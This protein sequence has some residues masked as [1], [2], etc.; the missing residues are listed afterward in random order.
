MSIVVNAVARIGSI[1]ATR[2]EIGIV[3]GSVPNAGTPGRTRMMTCVNTWM[4]TAMIRK[5]FLTVALVALVAGAGRPASRVEQAARLSEATMAD[6]IWIST[7]GNLNAAGSYSPSGVPIA[8]GNIVFDGSSNVDVSTGL[9]GLTG[10]DLRR[11]WTQPDYEGDIGASGN[12]LTTAA[13]R[14]IVQGSGSV[15]YAQET[16]SGGTPVIVVDSPNQQDAFSLVSTA[17]AYDLY[18]QN[19]GVEILPGAGVLGYLGVASRQSHLLPNVTIGTGFSCSYYV[20][21]SGYVTSKSKLGDTSCVIDGGIFV[22]DAS[23]TGGWGT[24]INIAG[25]TMIYNSAGSGSYIIVSSGTLD[26]SQDSRAKTISLLVLLPGAN[27]I[28]HNNITV[29]SLI[30]LRGIV[31][32]LP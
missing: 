10:V 24:V 4:R 5:W 7:D 26:M 15:W 21:K 20:Q 6:S 16:Y 9:T 8:A 22:Y 13:V 3:A 31:P 23:A 19:G 30:D 12:P 27:F 2:S 18:C 17:G 28:T 25:G 1:L 29:T 11:I 32:V 14:F